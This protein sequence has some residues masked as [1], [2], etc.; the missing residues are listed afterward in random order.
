MKT[1]V[2]AVYMMPGPSEHADGVEVVGGAGHDVAGA[3][4]L[5]EAVGQT[6]EMGEQIVAEVELDLARDA[7]HDPAREVLEDA[8]GERDG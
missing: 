8:F 5:V 3:G 6:F 7:D 1:T 4:A 2:L